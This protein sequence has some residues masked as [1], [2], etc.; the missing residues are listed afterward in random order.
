[1][2]THDMHPPTFSTELSQSSRLSSVALMLLP[3]L[4]LLSAF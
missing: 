1:M 4:E 3:V 2:S